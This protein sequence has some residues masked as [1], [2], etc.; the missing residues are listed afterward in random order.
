MNWLILVGVATV[1]DAARIFIDNYASDYYFKGREALAQKLFYGYAY[2]I[3]VVPILIIFSGE[4]VSA[5]I[6]TVLLLMLSG[7]MHGL[8]GIPYF[9]ALEL[10]NSTN[11]GIFIQLAPVLYLVLGWLFLGESFSPLQLVAIGVILLAPIIIVATARKRS[12]KI[13]LKA[14]FFAFL[15]VLIAV[16]SNLVFVQ[17]SDGSLSLVP[18]IALVL[19]GKGIAN[20]VIVYSR[21]KLRRRFI[22]VMKT[23]HYKVLR[24]MLCNHVVGFLKEFAYR[25][26]LIMA[27]AVA[28]A[29]AASDSVTPVVIF[30][31]G[32]VLSIIWPDFGREK[33]NRRNVIIHLIATILVVAG[34]V[35]LQF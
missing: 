32:I 12:R 10:D 23:S 15:Y 34:I 31:M 17:V 21:P 27:P 3:T 7:F 11:L 2:F 26:A 35:M 5:N 24:P 20:L 25:G 28:V 30:F 16:V 18:E 29:S 33:L 13:R 19:V 8:S 4:I 22:Y 9:K 14:V 1:L 6:V